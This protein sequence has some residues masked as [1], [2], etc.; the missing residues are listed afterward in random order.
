MA[1]IA[2]EGLRYSNLV[3]YELNP[4]MAYCRRA[5][6]VNEAAEAEYVVGTALGTVTADGKLK[7]SVETAVDG[8]ETVSA[9]VLEEKTVPAATDTKVLA[10]VRGPAIV[11]KAA[12]VLDASYDDDAKKQAAYDALEALGILVNDQ[13]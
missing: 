7:V 10:L 12:I 3:K 11:G 5:V 2:T 6:T 8:S 1:T 9:L 4:A 13:L